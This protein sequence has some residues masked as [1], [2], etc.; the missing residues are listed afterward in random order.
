MRKILQ[1]RETAVTAARSVSTGATNALSA[2]AAFYG[3]GQANMN[4]FIAGLMSRSQAVTDAIQTLM[5]EAIQA[6]R[7][8]LGIQ[9]PSRVF[10]QIGAYAA[11]GY[12]LG[13]AERMNAAERLI[14]QRLN[15]SAKAA[16]IGLDE[17]RRESSSR[18]AG[19]GIHI[20]Q[21]VYA[22]E[23]SYAGQQREAA[24]QLRVIARQIRG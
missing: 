17:G 23:T 2:Y 19:G 7:D 20:T 13:F 5:A 3:M 4:G 11:D 9:S 8:T 16:V 10:A 12:S 18:T 22:N 24:R 21:H 14:Q 1:K 15:Q 6:A